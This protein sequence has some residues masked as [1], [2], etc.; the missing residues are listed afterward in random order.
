MRRKLVAIIVALLLGFNM[1]SAQEDSDNKNFSGAY[2]CELNSYGGIKFDRTTLRWEGTSFPNAKQTLVVHLEAQFTQPPIV[3]YKV[4]TG[5]KDDKELYHC[6][7]RST[8]DVN[9]Y[10]LKGVISCKFGTQ[11]ITMNLNTMRFQFY[12]PGSYT[13]NN[14]AM[15]D[16]PT[17][18][19]GECRK[20]K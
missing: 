9:V 20:V 18:A 8:H 13:S 19:V 2:L 16:N 1:A 5:D 10:S 14:K 4:G 17:V 6:L 12:S 7:D 15:M 3:F 11:D